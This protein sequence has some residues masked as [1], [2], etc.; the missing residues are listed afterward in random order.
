[1][2]N[3]REKVIVVEADPG[4]RASLAAALEAAGYAAAA[5]A[6]LEESTEALHRDGADVLI[7]D[8]GAGG[9]CDPAARELVA[10]V[11]GS[12]ATEGVRVILIVEMAPRNGPRR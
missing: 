9:A 5:F 7:L 8:A 4:T 3:E 10:A 6:T 12:K 2:S 11:R 1:M